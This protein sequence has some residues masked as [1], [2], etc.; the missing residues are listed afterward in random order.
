MGSILFG[1]F[2]SIA[3]SVIFFLFM[4]AWWMGGGVLGVVFVFLYCFSLFFYIEGI[5]SGDILV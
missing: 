2:F 5:G 4:D 1:F 3:Y